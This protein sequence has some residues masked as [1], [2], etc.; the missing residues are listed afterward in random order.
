MNKY[1]FLSLTCF[2]IGIIFFILG[3]LQGEIQTGFFVVFPFLIGSGIYAFAGIIFI[4]LALSLFI[5]GFSKNIESNETEV[6]EE[7]A[8]SIKKTSVK[9]GGIVLIGP[10]PIVFGSSWKIALVLMIAAIILILVAF[11]AFRLI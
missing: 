2:I 11:F 8:Q 10:L 5:F 9:G 3:F 7:G 6:H 1:H 4:F